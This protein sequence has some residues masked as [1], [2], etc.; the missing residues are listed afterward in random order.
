MWGLLRRRPS[1]SAERDG[2]LAAVEQARRLAGQGRFRAAI[3]GLAQHGAEGLDPATLRD[4]VQWRRLAFDPQPGAAQWPA[5]FADPFPGQPGPPEIAVADLTAAVLGGALQHHG[6]LIVRGIITPDETRRLEAIVRRAFQAAEAAESGGGDEADQA[7]FSPFPLGPEDEMGAGDRAFTRAC[8]AVWTADSPRALAEFIGFLKA[9]GVIDVIEAY[10]GERGF[11]S[12][13]KSSL[14]IV[15]PTTFT[16]WHQD[17]AFLGPEIRTVNVWL[18]LSDCGEDAPGLDIY[19]RRLNGLAETGTQGAIASWTV[20]EGVVEELARTAPI[21]SPRFKAGDA[22]LF[23]QLFL[24]RTGVRPGMT[25]ERLAIESWI[26]AGST[27][28]MKQVPIAL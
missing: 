2:G 14:R 15:P 12:L 5:R 3:D 4:L 10:L 7:W 6:C 22:M 24:H 20:G 21:L 27:F 8:G 16:N 18:A 17:G 13:G 9:H 1:G 23:D 19:P 25:R 28:P 26:F 11:L